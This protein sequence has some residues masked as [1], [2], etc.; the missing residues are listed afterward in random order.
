MIYKESDPLR[1]LT[2]FLIFEKIIFIC[3]NLIVRVSEF[4]SGIHLC[5]GPTAI[6]KSLS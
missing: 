5:V 4:L 1:D 6:N 2:P 3:Y